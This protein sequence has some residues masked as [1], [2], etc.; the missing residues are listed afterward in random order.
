MKKYLILLLILFGCQKTPIYKTD[1]NIPV[2]F[3]MT[4]VG[5][6]ANDHTGDPIR[7]FAQKQN[8]NWN[9][10]D[11]LFGTI[12]SETETK[13]VIN[14]SLNARVAAAYNATTYF[15]TKSD[16][17]TYKKPMT[18]NGVVNYVAAHGG[19]GSGGYEWTSWIVGLTSGAPANTDTSFTISS[20]AGDRIELYRGTTTDLHNQWLNEAATNVRT[21]YRY[22]SSG[23]IVVRPAWSTGDRAYLRSVPSASAT[24]ITL[25]GGG[26]TLQTGL[27]AFYQLNEGVGVTSVADVLAT[28][29]G[30][31]N[32]LCGATGKF[33]YA[34]SFTKASSQ[35]IS[36][37]TT[38]GDVGTNDFSL[39]CWIYVP[40]LQSAYCGI[41]GNFGS[42]PYFYLMLN[43]ANYLEAVINFGSGNILINSNSAISATTWYNVIITYDRSGN[44][45]MY[46][47]GSAQTDVEDISAGVA[48]DITNANNFN[49]GQIGS[50]YSTWYWSG[51]IDAPGI[52]TKILSAPEMTTLQTYTHPFE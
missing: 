11:A 33:G 51:L 9:T 30:T 39:S 45:T 29:N 35:Y 10:A 2:T 48:V 15:N 36:A 12:Y 8:T 24:K 27:R 40:T 23:T 22:N 26:S 13:D 46:L 44:G 28:Y 32:A 41:M 25:S 16:T 19:S 7:T 31:T 6:T 34:E 49:I 37:G 47:N 43:D 3:Q 38:L 1:R 21:G 4:N 5:T 52:W 17:N 50:Q 18:Y 14:D 42:G 20:F